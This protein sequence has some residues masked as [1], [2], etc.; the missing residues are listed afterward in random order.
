M[1]EALTAVHEQSQKIEELHYDLSTQF[2]ELV[3]GAMRT[4]FALYYD[5]TDLIG[6]DGRSLDKTTRDGCEDAKQM[7]RTNPNLWFG[8]RRT[9]LERQEFEELL[10]MGRGEGPNTKVVVSDFPQELMNAKEDVG[11]YNVTRKQ[12][13][14]RILIRKPDGNLHMYSQSLDSSNREALEAIYA[15]FGLMP[16]PGELLGQRIDANLSWEQQETLAS[17]LAGVYDRSLSEQ[18]GGEWHAGRR[19]VDYRNTYDFVCRQ[20]DLITECI[21]LNS[22]GWLNEGI[23]YKMS[24]TMNKRFKAELQPNE[25]EALPVQI[26]NPDNLQEWL[27]NEIET[28]GA[29]ARQAGMTFSACGVTLGGEGMANNSF[30]QAGYGDKTKPKDCEFVSKKCPVCGEKN[31]KTKVK[32]GVYHHVG[33]SCSS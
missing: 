24:A 12:T 22:L 8:V 30:E 25:L 4:D 21:R 29:E 1:S 10:T 7:A 26:V 3:D 23:M 17:E 31:A 11:G 28:A 19:P 5:G 15:H 18:F 2:A 27:Y 33:K 20:Q 16:E 6:E 13:M 9:S 14:L 32:D